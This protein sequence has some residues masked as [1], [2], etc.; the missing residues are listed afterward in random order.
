MCPVM[1]H[2]TRTNWYAMYDM[3]HIESREAGRP[4][5]SWFADPAGSA[6][7]DLR[8]SRECADAVRDY[9]VTKGRDGSA[10]RTVAFGKTRL[11]RPGAPGTADGVVM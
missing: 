5:V 6:A 8:L 10:L 9:L 3:Q 4:S 1:S 7:Y 2:T 11:V